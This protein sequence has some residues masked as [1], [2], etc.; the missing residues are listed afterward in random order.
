VAGT[1]K[2]NTRDM[3]A[4]GRAKFAGRCLTLQ[5]VASVRQR[6]AAGEVQRAI[7]RELQVHP[8]TINRIVKGRSWEGVGLSG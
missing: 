8:V 7:A 1:P 5:Q 2:T 4:K 6:V 3:M